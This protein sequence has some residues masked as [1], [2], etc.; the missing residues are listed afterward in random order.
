MYLNIN[1]MSQYYKSAIRPIVE[2]AS[3]L[4]DNCSQYDMLHLENVQRRA[5]VVCTGALKRTESAKLLNDLCWESIKTR[6]LKAKL[7]LLLKIKKGLVP[8]YLKIL[9][10]QIV[11]RQIKYDLR[12]KAKQYNIETRLKTYE[13]SYFPST[14]KLWDELPLNVSSSHTISEFKKGLGV[15]MCVVPDDHFVHSY[16]FYHCCGYYGRILNQIRYELSPLRSH[17]FTYNISDNPMC[18]SCYDSVETTR[19]YFIECKS[20]EISRNNLI[21]TL[22]VLFNRHN[23][24]CDITNSDNLLRTILLGTECN[25]FENSLA[26]EINKIIFNAVVCYMSES[27][28]FCR[29]LF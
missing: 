12:T 10:P 26:N 6:R 15:H 21:F 13:L 4:F 23:I 9:L 3:V 18:P 16:L 27:K 1:Q 28:R 25:N 11:D 14:I 24:E 22:N 5:A 17:L 2:Y 19:H 20:Y 7:I 29:K 8:D